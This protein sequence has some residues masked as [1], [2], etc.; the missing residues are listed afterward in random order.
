MPLS[1]DKGEILRFLAASVEAVRLKVDG[2]DERFIAMEGR[3]A[4]IESRMATKDDITIVRGDI[5]RVDLRLDG[6]D[7]A[8]LSRANQVDA[9]LLRHDLEYDRWRIQ[10]LQDWRWNPLIYT[11]LAG[12]SVYTLLAREFA[13]APDRLK[14]LGKRLDE[15]PRFLGQVRD[16]LEPARV[17]KIH[18]ETAV[19]QNA[20]LISMLDGE[21]TQQIDAL[22]AADQEALRASVARARSALS[23]HQIWLEKRLT[24]EA[25]GDFRLGQQ[26]YDQ[27]LAYALFSPLSREEIKARAEAELVATRNAMYGIARQVLK[28]KRNAPALPEKP[29]ATQ[30][31]RAI[32][33]SLASLSCLPRKSRS[34]RCR[35]PPGS[36]CPCIRHSRSRPEW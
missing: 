5:E 35:T 19:K 6:I 9:L 7:R 1:P 27:K 18:A 32:S 22:P 17:P 2:I 4:T 23:Q 11:R 28:G 8:S 24:P 15:L 21:V 14:N 31:Q 25:K 30:Q 34:G 29:S 36:A 3:V 12:D 26:L 10:T 13:P 16:V 20:G 33:A